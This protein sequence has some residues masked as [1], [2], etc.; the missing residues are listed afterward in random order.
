SWCK[1]DL[2]PELY[3]YRNWLSRRLYPD[4]KW[5]PDGIPVMFYSVH[6]TKDFEKTD[7]LLTILAQCSLPEVIKKSKCSSSEAALPVSCRLGTSEEREFRQADPEGYA[8]S[9]C[10][11]LQ[12]RQDHPI[13]WAGSWYKR[14]EDVPE[15][16]ALP[17]KQ[18]RHCILI[19]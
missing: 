12:P 4:P 1:F 18:P 14:K 5:Y 10:C 11:C 15:L 9:V 13:Y 16:S 17:T 7:Q 8:A 2:E 6:N 3:T 19:S